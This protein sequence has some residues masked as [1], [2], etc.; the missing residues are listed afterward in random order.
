MRKKPRKLDKPDKRKKNPGGPVHTQFKKGQSGNPLGGKLHNPIKRA[1]KNLTVDTYREVIELVCQNDIDAL[2]EMSES[3][4]ITALQVGVARAFLKAMRDGDYGT[5]ERIAERIV[6]KIPDKLEVT[7][8][9]VNR[10]LNVNAEVSDEILKHA[11][12]KLRDDV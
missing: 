8:D 3:R 2:E 11:L 1:L 10:N 7:G 5:I 4:T 12:A 6:G 9:N